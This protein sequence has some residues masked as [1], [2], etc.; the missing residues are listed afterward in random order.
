MT[1]LIQE[2]INQ[3]YLKSPQII[4][5]FKKVR[6]EDFLPQNLKEEA[7]L[8]IPLPIGYGQT[9]SQPLT[10]AFMLELL[11]PQKGEKI[12]DVG[13][14]SGWVAA[15]LAQIVGENGK[16][17][18]IEL[19]PELKKFG[20]ENAAK[21][22]F[23]EKGIAEFFC[24][25]GADGL[26]DKAPFDKIHIAAA[27]L[28]IPEPLKE[29]LKIGGRLVMPVGESFSQSLVLLEKKGKNKYKEIHYPGFVF[30]PLISARP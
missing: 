1:N 8:N 28:K 11:Q 5:A 29:Q 7:A 13:A 21:Y 27:A 19:I 12:L 24:S 22:N 18:A 16:I 6:R 26:P 3:G 4:E 17:Y 30:V 9:I 14:G 25:D 15:L 20:E 10:V 23:F 2:L